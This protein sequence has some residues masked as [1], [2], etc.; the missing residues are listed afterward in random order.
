MKT[1]STFCMLVLCIV[2]LT[3]HSHYAFGR[4]PRP[5]ERRVDQSQGS[6]LLIGDHPGIDEKDVQNV[7][8]LVVQELRKQG[9]R[10]GDP[11]HE[12]PV[13]GPVYRVVLRRSNE[14]KKILF[15]LSEE[16]TAG[17]IIVER[18]M[19]LAD[20]EA[21]VSA[22]PRVVYALVHRKPVTAD[23]LVMGVR[24]FTTIVPI[25]E[26]LPFG[27]RFGWNVDRLSYTVD[28]EGQIAYGETGYQSTNRNYDLLFSSVS[29]G[30]RYFF[31]KQNIAPYIGGGFAGMSA[32]YTTTVRTPAEGFI[33][34][35]SLLFGGDE[36][37]YNSDSEEVLGIGAYGVLGIEI[38]RFSRGRL[39]LE[40]RVDRP[41]FQ[42]PSLD[43][44][45]ITLGIAGGWAF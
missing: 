36:W 42:L 14:N 2:L 38:G 16:D 13:S 19:L 34:A 40:L 30:G 35:L 45:P 11:V 4:G 1:S 28:M 43:V 15:R 20:I 10:V 39:K 29:L 12:I 8:L 24:V 9:I 6:I 26:V 21:V 37:E 44:M 31:S 23:S 22:G 32:K 27:V 17:T 33:A 18:E 41:F 25:E 7:A 3:F 5:T